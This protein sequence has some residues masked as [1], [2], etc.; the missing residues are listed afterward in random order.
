MKKVTIIATAIVLFFAST[1]YAFEPEKV[2]P[3]VKSI[4]Q[5]D[6]ARA[7]KV[8]WKKSANFYFA[9][10]ILDNKAVS[11]AYDERGELAG[12]SVVIAK[13]DLPSTITQSIAKKYDGYTISGK[14][15]EVSYE[16]QTSYFFTAD[17]D[18]QQLDL[19]SDSDGN[20]TVKNK[21]KK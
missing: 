1:S 4:F 5:Q 10:F 12:T 9:D 6:F 14:V 13:S 18:K 21:I 11:A 7:E 20:I 3:L 17:N 8:T 16:G 15:T 2:S 19:V